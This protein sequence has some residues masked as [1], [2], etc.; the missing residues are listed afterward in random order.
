MDSRAAVEP[1]AFFRI[2]LITAATAVDAVAATATDESDGVAA[3]VS[4]AY[5]RAVELAA[6][7][8][9]ESAAGAATTMLKSF[10]TV[11]S[12]FRTPASYAFTIAVNV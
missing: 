2:T 3:Y 6:F 4:P 8:T 5:I 12:V 11:L 9:F 1:E 7:A 10:V